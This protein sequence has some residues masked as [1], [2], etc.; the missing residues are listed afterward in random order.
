MI[1]RVHKLIRHEQKPPTAVVDLLMRTLI[2]TNGTLYQLLDTK[3]KINDLQR[4]HFFFIERNG[5]AI[6]NLTI[7]EREVIL[8]GKNTNSF[9]I[10][11]FAFDT[12]FQ[13]GSKKGQAN[14]RFHQYFRAFFKTSNFNPV[15]PEYEKSVFWAFIDPENLRSFNMNEHFGFQTIGQFQTTAFSR[16]K[17]Q[18]HNVSRIQSEEKVE[19]LELIRK[20]YRDHQFFSPV[21]LFENDNY[22]ILRKNGEI[23][24]GIQA[25]PV[26]WQIKSLPGIM[27]K[28]LI[29]GAPYTPGIRKLINPKNHRFLATEGLFWGEGY[30]KEVEN[31]LEGV[32]ALTNHHSMLIWT[33][34]K[35]THLNDLP[36][37]W[38]LIQNMK[39]NNTVHVVA[40]FNGYSKEYVETLKSK[41]IYFS[42]F[43]M[44]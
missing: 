44:T 24:A 30:E 3:M 38:G 5:K 42:G 9:Y 28:F 22:Y 29:K 13:G 14:S 18:T 43:D 1:D 31:L 33:D 6:G 39:K 10:R 2:G 17:P 15:E 4:P 20:F 37:S 25:N 16:V 12:L 23:V 35:D 8:N 36:I 7:C 34:T 19:V 40:K 32:L 11:Y 21:H 41:S 26:A 27:G